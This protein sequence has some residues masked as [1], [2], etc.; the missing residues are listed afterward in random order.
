MPWITA[1]IMACASH[2]TTKTAIQMPTPSSQST[3]PRPSWRRITRPT[4]CPA[5]HHGPAQRQRRSLR[6]QVQPQHGTSPY[7]AKRTVPATTTFS[8]ATTLTAS[9]TSASS[10][11]VAIFPYINYREFMRVVHQ[12]RQHSGQLQCRIPD[13][14]AFMES[15]RRRLH[16][17]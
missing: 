6:P 16:G 8:R 11:A 15:P 2:Q 9:P 14:A 12:R 10:S 3:F 13:P 1:C 5:G 7:T 4:I 17:L